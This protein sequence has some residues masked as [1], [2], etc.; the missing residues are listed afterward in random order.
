MCEKTLEEEGVHGDITVADF[1]LDLIPL[2]EDVISMENAD[3]LKEVRA[4]YD[5]FKPL[6]HSELM[7]RPTSPLSA[8]CWATKRHCSTP[9]RA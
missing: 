5:C 1:N 9:P 4:H 6:E 7:P 3:S 2:N 8:R